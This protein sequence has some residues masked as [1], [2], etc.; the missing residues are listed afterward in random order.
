ML[1][2]EE[3]AAL[4]ERIETCPYYGIRNNV[5]MSDLITL[6]YNMLIVPEARKAL[7]LDLRDKVVIFD[8]AHNVID[9]VRGAYSITITEQQVIFL[10]FFA[11]RKIEL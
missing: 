2:I 11:E 9:S 1:D 6:P 4:A 10:P 5:S 7:G 3:L 8:E